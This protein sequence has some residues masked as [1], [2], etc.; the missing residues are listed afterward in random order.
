MAFCKNCGKELKKGEKCSCESEVKFCKNCGKKL[1]GDA[2]CDCNASK[3]SSSNSSGFDFVQTMKNIKDDM[4]SSLK[5]P[6]SVIKE[7]TDKEDMPK[8]YIVLVLVALTF[9]LFVASLCKT[10][11]ATLV[12]SMMGGMSSLIKSSDIMDAVKI[13]YFKIIIFGALILAIML[14]AYAVIMLVVPSIFKNKKIGFKQSL[15]LTVSAFAPLAMANLICAILG[16]LGLNATFVLIL[17]LVANMIVTYNFI[18][19]YAQYTKVDSNKF[20]YAITLLVVLASLI[21]GICT[22]A[23]SNSMAKS[24]SQ[25]IVDIDTD[26][27]EDLLDY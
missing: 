6:V 24:I 15:T 2:T 8:T 19:S 20:G 18:Y 3:S 12:S 7:N 17:Y 25:D 16:F 23:L 9:G 22:Y 14:F 1:V 4:I 11:F 13:P 26:D 27:L 21:V 5:N 10:L